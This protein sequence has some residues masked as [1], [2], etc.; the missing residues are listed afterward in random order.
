[1][2]SFHIYVLLIILVVNAYTVGVQT[3]RNVFIGAKT[4]DKALQVLFYMFLGSLV[5]VTAATV[6]VIRSIRK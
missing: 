5:I 4:R 6:D 2:N 3:Q 1:M